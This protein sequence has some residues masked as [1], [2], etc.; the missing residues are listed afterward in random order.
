MKRKRIKYVVLA[1]S[2]FSE[3]ALEKCAQR[4]QDLRDIIS[5]RRTPEEVQRDNWWML[6]DPREFVSTN[7]RE[8]CERL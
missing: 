1:P 8:A 6:P 3:I 7:L 2:D 5:G 4:E